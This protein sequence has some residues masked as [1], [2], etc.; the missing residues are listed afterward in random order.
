MNKE[1]EIEFSKLKLAYIAVKYFLQEES[2]EEIKSTKDRVSEDLGLD[3]DDNYFMLLKF[4]NKFELEF[5]DFIYDEHFHSEGE[6]FGSEAA[7]WNIITLS[8][9]L[10]LK[11]IELL[12]LNKLKLS[13][14]A[15]FT[16][17]RTVKDLT[18][19]EMVNWYIEGKF[20]TSSIKYIIASNGNNTNASDI[21]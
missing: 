1:V 9:W 4:V 17:N 5:S 8:I 14:P 7:F 2:F 20:P 13:M 21:K 16:T 6:L 10:P 18:F 3:G 15:F 11:T 12:T 19:R